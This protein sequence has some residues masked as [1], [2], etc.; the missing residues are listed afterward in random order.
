M[1]EATLYLKC[2]PGDVAERVLLTGDPARIERIARVLEQ[3]REV[4]RNREF[5]VLTGLYQGV[6]VSAISGGIGAPSTAIALEELALLGVTTVARI[7]T[8]MGIHAP[9]QSV[10]VPTGAVRYEGTSESYL[11]PAYPAVPHWGLAHALAAAG[12][13]HALDV[14]L[15]LTA[16]FD[17]FY[18]RMGASL[19]GRGRLDLSLPRQVGVLSM[20]METSLI[21][22][23]GATLGLAAAAMCLVTVQADPHAQLDGRPREALDATLVRAALDGLTAFEAES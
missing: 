3:P 10:V 23:A 9:L 20:D 13:R 2:K 12:R 21:F 11:P 17:A 5:T 4:S 15:G 16:T 7:G 6:P 8:M 14:R 18:P 19:V 1:N 22:V